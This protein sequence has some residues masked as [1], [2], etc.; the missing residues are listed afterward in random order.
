MLVEHFS[1]E[2]QLRGMVVQH[3]EEK[4]PGRTYSSLPA[5]KGATGKLERDCHVMTEKRVRV[6]D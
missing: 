1:S 2:E 3:R 4:T 6:S 5:S